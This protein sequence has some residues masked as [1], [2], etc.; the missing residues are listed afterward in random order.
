MNKE[1]LKALLKY[2][3]AKKPL[4]FCVFCCTWSKIT[5]VVD[6]IEHFFK[7]L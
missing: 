7:Y 5:F 6:F 1:Q 2:Q 4:F 3:E